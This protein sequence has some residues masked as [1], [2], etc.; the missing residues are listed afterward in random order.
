MELDESYKLKIWNSWLKIYATL[1]NYRAI[2]TAYVW[3]TEGAS[4]ILGGWM[5]YKVNFAKLGV[6]ECE[7][8]SSLTHA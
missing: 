6:K 1:G 2:P 8:S 5:K 4:K 3:H 7:R